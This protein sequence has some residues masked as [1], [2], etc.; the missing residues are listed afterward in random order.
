MKAAGRHPLN[1][2]LIEK[3][4]TVRKSRKLLSTYLTAGK[5]FSNAT[6]TRSRILYSLKPYGTDT[7]RLASKEHHFW[8]GLQI[9]NIPRGPAVK[10]TL[11]ADPDFLLYEADY[12]AAESRGTGYLAGCE[13]IIRNVEGP[14][15]F[16]SLNASA[17]FGTPY[18]EIFD[19]A[20]HKQL[21]KGLRD[22][23]KRTNHG[24]NYLM[25]PQVMVE[26]MGLPAIYKAQSLLNLPRLWMPKQVAEYLL[27]RF[28]STY[29]ELRRLFYPGVVAEIIKT[30]MLRGPTG[31]TRYCFGSPD[32]NK[33]DLNAYVAHM[34]QS[35][36]AMILN[37]A[38]LAIFYK[39]GFNPNFKLLCQVHDSI[40]FQV[41][42]GHEH[43]V[44]EL[45]HEMVFPVEIIGAD[46]KSR[47]MVVPVDVSSGGERWSTIK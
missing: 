27:E 37:Q 35:L 14:H 6:G 7:G 21:N 9:Q 12:S 31:W 15:D 11:V 30:R 38:F 39:L 32:K 41:R 36:N 46:G 17:F 2:I 16:H 43:L 1:A 20:A 3:I 34:P 5:E 18:E 45:E 10:R 23:A 28:H 25:G 40:L 42:K 44:A 24:A 22:L 29:P 26:T 19:D 13:A 33:R 47:A 8:S 4:L